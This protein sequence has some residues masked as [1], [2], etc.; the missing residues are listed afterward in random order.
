MVSTVRPALIVII[1]L[2]TAGVAGWIVVSQ[3]HADMQ[4]ADAARAAIAVG[5]YNDA[6]RESAA[7]R[8]LSGERTAAQRL[9]QEAQDA[10]LRARGAY[11]STLATYNASAGDMYNA[12]GAPQAMFDQTI[13]TAKQLLVRPFAFSLSDAALHNLLAPPKSHLYVAVLSPTPATTTPYD[14]RNCAVQQLLAGSVGSMRR[15]LWNGARGVSG[16]RRHQGTNYSRLWQSDRRR[17]NGRLARS[18]CTIA[19]V[20]CLCGSR[21]RS[22]S[23]SGMGLRIV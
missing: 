19:P 2:V 3:R 14:V 21:V 17:S 16:P 18:I 4:H 11:A 20:R 5:N 23:C 22:S 7:I 12:A 15:T 10:D 9:I 6:Q 8:W 13:A 1:M